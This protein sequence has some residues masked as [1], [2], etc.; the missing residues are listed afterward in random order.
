MAVNAKPDAAFARAQRTVQ[1]LAA[2]ADPTRLRIVEIVAARGEICSCD[3]LAPLGKSQPTVSHH[4]SIL[5]RAGVLVGRKRG[6][7]TWWSVDAGV[8]GELSVALARCEP[9]PVAQSAL[10][11]TA[12]VR[13][14][15]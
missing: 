4:T 10:L 14:R 1:L 5:A 3:L 6:R 7:W 13:A 11:A 2:L 9:S 15:R 8:V 12:K